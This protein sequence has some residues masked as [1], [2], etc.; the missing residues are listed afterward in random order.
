MERA[1]TI[2]ALATLAAP[3]LPAP[4]EL[5]ERAPDLA[6]LLPETTFAAAGFP[7]L[8][9]LLERGFEDPLVTSLLESPAGRLVLSRSEVTPRSAVLYAGA[10]AGEPLLPALASL[11]REGVWVALVPSPSGPTGLLVARGD[12]PARWERLLDRALETL[13]D[14]PDVPPGLPEAFER[15][16]DARLWD[17]GEAGAFAQKGALFVLSG[18]RAL[19]ERTLR[20]AEELPTVE[21]R[22]SSPAEARPLALAWL[23]RARAERALGSEAVAEWSSAARDPGVHFLLGSDLALLSTAER[24]EARLDLEGNRVRF[25][26]LGRGV[27]FGAAGPLVTPLDEAAPPRWPAATP[28]TEARALL[29]RDVAA[30]FARR[31]ELFPATALP[32]FAQAVSDL[33]PLFGGLD[34]EEELLPALDPWVR[35]VVRDV[36]LDPS[37]A[38]TVRLPAAA[39]LVDLREPQRVGS[40]LVAAFQSLVAITNVERAQAGRPPLVLSLERIGD[41]EMTRASFPPPMPGDEVDVAYNLEPAC[42]LAGRTF[43]IG[44]HAAL[45]REI[46]GEIERGE[47]EDPPSGGDRWEVFGSAIS[48]LLTENRAPLVSNGVLNEGKSPEEARFEADLL[49]ALAAGLERLALSTERAAEDALRATLEIELVPHGGED[50]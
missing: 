26:V 25:E 18:N 27:E 29:R 24:L 17:L 14:S 33:G 28:G 35:I 36:E 2:L 1:L 43:V 42:V 10:L 30:L 47:F 40:R 11:V 48:Q 45:V 19:V 13:A 12:D 16:G 37:A 15:V 32:A 22:R 21:T 5:P 49:A 3:S 44:S 50:R 6:E 41:L 4:G 46:I 38:P 9:D 31:A 8:C 34:L 23:D 7:G 39:L 20:R